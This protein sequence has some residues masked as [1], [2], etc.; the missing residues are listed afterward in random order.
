MAKAASIVK[1]IHDND[2]EKVLKK[3]GFYEKLVRRE[4]RCA[5]CGRQLTLENLAR[6]YRENEEVKLVCN[7][8]GCLVQE[9]FS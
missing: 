2:L 7:R 6:P 8:I 4:L 3:L 1:T 5:I 9:E